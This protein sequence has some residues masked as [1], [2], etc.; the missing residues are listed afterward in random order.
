VADGGLHG[1]LA[2][3]PRRAVAQGEHAGLARSL[4]SLGVTL[5]RNGEAVDTGKGAN[6]LDGPIEALAYLVDVLGRD[7]V[8]PPLR[9]G[10]LVTTGTLTRAFPVAAGEQWSTQIDGYPLPG[11]SVV[12]G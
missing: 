6:A 5:S 12:F 4:A 10:E 7:P 1:L 3:G 8:N 9:A 2:V 11:L